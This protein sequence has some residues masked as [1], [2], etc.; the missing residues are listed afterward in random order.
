MSLDQLRALFARP[1]PVHDAG[2]AQG[3]VPVQAVG[4]P[5]W[6]AILAAA[7]MVRPEAWAAVIAGPARRYGINNRLRA[8]AFA[9]TIAHESGGG[10]RMV[11]SLNYRPEAL[12]AT[13]P[14]RFSPEDA[15]RMGRADGKPADQRAIAE[16][17]Y[18][19]RMGNGP[20]GS[21]DGWRYRGR[22]LI[23]LTGRDA[24]RR[25]GQA[26]GLP[27]EDQP[28]IAEQEGVA[29]EVACWT[30]GAWK[31]CNPLADAEDVDGWRRAINGGLN[32]LGDVKARYAAALAS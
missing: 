21:G 7:G 10:A 6:R 26:T 24:Y 22:G 17:A 29:A 16:R 18:G 27:L 5:N 15:R 3:T 1:H 12:L 31:G 8:C 28:E 11:E 4:E 13:W 20:E 25:A 14:H 32:G 23:Q 2:I 9:A 19:G 30:W